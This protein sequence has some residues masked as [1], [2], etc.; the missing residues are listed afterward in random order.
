MLPD[1]EKGAPPKFPVEE[2]STILPGLQKQELGQF[3]DMKKNEIIPLGVDEASNENFPQASEVSRNLSSMH[4]A[5][6]YQLPLNEDVTKN[7]EV[8][9]KENLQ[10]LKPNGQHWVPDVGINQK[11]DAQNPCPSLEH[12]AR[13]GQFSS[14]ASLDQSSRIRS[15]KTGGHES[16]TG[17]FTVKSDAASGLQSYSNLQEATETTNE[18]LF[19]NGLWDSQIASHQSA[20]EKFSVTKDSGVSSFSTLSNA[21]IRAYRNQIYSMDNANVNAAKV[22]ASLGQKPFDVHDTEGVLPAVSYA[23][24]PVQSKGQQ[25]NKGAGN[26]ESLSGCS[27]E[28]PLNE[29]TMVGKSSICKFRASNEQHRASSTLGILTSEPNLSKQFGNVLFPKSFHNFYACLKW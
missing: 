18:L 13:L 1:E 11:S 25:T 27:S 10:S 9:S 4:F 8:E 23:S 24:R 3:Q 26:T 28:L 2:C 12:N 15:Q 20:G 19:K 7:Q 5:N 17:S 21:Q 6:P 22:H 29:N 16:S 14:S